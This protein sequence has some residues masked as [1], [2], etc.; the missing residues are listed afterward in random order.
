MKQ[1][2]FFILFL[3]YLFSQAQSDLPSKS[4]FGNVHTPKGDLH[5]LVIFVRYDDVCLFK[6]SLQWPDSTQKGT[7]PEIALGDPNELFYTDPDMLTMSFETGD[8]KRNISDYFYAMSGGKFRITADIF[9]EQVPVK[10]IRETGRNFFSRQAE[11]NTAAVEWIV[12]HYPDFDWSRYDKRTNRPNYKYDNSDSRPDKIIDYIIF[13]HRDKGS[14]GMGASSH[15]K[16]PN[17]EYTIKD[18]H[19]GIKSYTDNKHNWEYFKHEFAH[20]LY[21]CPHYLGANSADGNKFYTQKG[22][23]LMAAWHSTFFTANA[24]ESWWL[25]WLTPQEIQKDGVYTIKDYLTGRDAIRIPLPGTKDYLWI[26]NHQKKDIRWDEKMFFKS[27]EQGHPQAVPGLYMY[28]VAEPGSDRYNP[29]L[30]PFNN[31]HANL[32]KMLNAE[33]NY[34]YVATGDS[35]HTGY[36]LCPLVEKTK[37]NPI[38]GQNAYQFIRADYNEDG[39]IAIG[40]AHGNS[41]RG[42]REQQDIWTEVIDGKPTYTLSATGD[43]NDALVVG[44]ELG[45]SGKFP[46]L[47]YPIFN[48]ANQ[49]LD[50][51]VLN[52]ISIKVLEQDAAGNFKLDI[53]LND[54][55]VSSSQRWC[56]NLLMPGQNKNLGDDNFLKIEDGGEILL[57]L[58][59][60]PD[61]EKIHPET[62]TFANPTKLIVET[63]RGIIIK[64]G[65][66]FIIDNLSELNLQ[67]NAQIIIENKGE[68]IIK[69]TGRL[70]ASDQNQIII[71]KGGRILVEKGADFDPDQSGFLQKERGGKIVRKAKI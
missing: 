44:D 7:L 13:M 49:S 56:G 12:E 65:G 6:D 27:E 68:L 3:T 15:I 36:F 47:N 60:T 42:A 18:G 62:G 55:T 50:P 22:W 26:E 19:T 17:S 48:R 41:D 59:G 52:G 40:M 16:I 34:D 5:M 8:R 14:T 43:E 67:K 11:M 54:W 57:D 23:G 9:P 30:N 31:K 58:S 64:K 70:I 69:K 63:N 28:V 1:I 25:G 33:G 2:S 4:Y 32:I 24:W 37:P 45:L 61:R 29:H 20:N 53:K 51:Y 38:A 35:L 66:K 46:L 39:Q 10:Y 21:N 71:E